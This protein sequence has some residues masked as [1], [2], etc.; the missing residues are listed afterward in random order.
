[1]K[2]LD[3]TLGGLLGVM[4]LLFHFTRVVVYMPIMAASFFI[5]TIVCTIY[6]AIVDGGK[7][8]WKL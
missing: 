2:L 6:G 5:N 1:M 3:L 8:A 4:T 7:I